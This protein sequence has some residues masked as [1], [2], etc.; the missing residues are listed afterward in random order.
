M[1]IS[2]RTIHVSVPRNIDP[3]RSAD[4]SGNVKARIK[5][6]EA[7]LSCEWLANID[8]ARWRAIYGETEGP[9]RSSGD[10][11]SKKL[12]GRTPMVAATKLEG[13]AS[14]LML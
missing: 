3:R 1:T 13:K 8:V 14:S 2:D 9:W 7:G 4:N 10:S 5:Y 11:T 12:S 6:F